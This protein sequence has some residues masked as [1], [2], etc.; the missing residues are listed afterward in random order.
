VVTLGG[1][2]RY[3]GKWKTAASRN[4]YRRL[5][6]QW[7]AT[8]GGLPTGHEA[9]DL[10]VAELLARCWRFAQAYYVKHWEQT[11]TLEGIRQALR[12][13]KQL[14]GTTPAND[15]GPVAAKRAFY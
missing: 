5:V 6:A 8:G 15:F 7:L 12:A 13:I 11:S 9:S 2:G 14:Y 10:T 1:K 3:L 4:A